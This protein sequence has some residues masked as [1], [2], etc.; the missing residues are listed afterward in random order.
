MD[1]GDIVGAGSVG[2]GL[3]SI[4]ATVAP[5]IPSQPRA[6]ASACPHTPREGRGR[7][8]GEGGKIEAGGRGGREGEERESEGGKG[9]RERGGR[10]GGREGERE[11]E[12]GA[13]RGVVHIWHLFSRDT[14]EREKSSHVF[15]WPLVAIRSGT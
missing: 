12:E 11:E 15:S 13:S 9:G 14:A 8:R 2:S 4:V 7:G 10:E 5:R 1:E 3:P 6:A